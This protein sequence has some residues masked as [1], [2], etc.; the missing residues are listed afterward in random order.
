[1]GV[2][3]RQDLE[4]GAVLRAQPK[5]RVAGPF[6][7]EFAFREFAVKTRFGVPWRVV[8]AKGH[9]GLPR[10]PH[11]SAHPDPTLTR[12]ELPMEI[13]KAPPR[14]QRPAQPIELELRLTE[15]KHE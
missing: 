15:A 11:R 13:S 1:M 8:I 14:Q 3:V 7:L 6:D 10:G 4:C 2:V 9:E 5:R 12:L